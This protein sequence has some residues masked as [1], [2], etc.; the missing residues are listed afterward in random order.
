MQLQNFYAQDVNGNIVPGAICSL[1]LPGT[2]TLATGLV[3]VNGSTLANPFAAN[4]NGLVQFAA[5]NGAYDLKIEAGLIVSTLP[6]VFADTLQALIQL[7]GFLPPSATPPTTRVDGSTLQIGDRYMKTP[8]DIEYIYKT[9]GWEPNN[10]DGQLLAAANGASLVTFTPEGPGAFNRELQEKVRERACVRDFGGPNTGDGVTDDSAAALAMASSLG[11]IRFTRGNYVINTCEF[12]VPVSFD[13]KANVKVNSGNTLSI[14]NVIESPKQYIFKGDGDFALGHNHV[15]DTGENARQVHVSWFGAFP[16]PDYGPDQAPFFK[17]A[18]DSMG[19]GRESEI[20]LDIGNYNIA[21]TSLMVMTRACHLKG[22]GQRRTVLKLSTDIGPALTTGNTACRVTGIGFELHSTFVSTRVNPF[23]QLNHD[24]CD[25]RDV[26]FGNTS[27]GLIINALNCRV[28][29]V[30]AGYNANPPAGS[31]LI[32]AKYG[33]STI[34]NIHCM[35]SSGFGPEQVIRLGNSIANNE[36]AFLVENVQS[37]LPSK[38]VT[39]D[40]TIGSVTNSI[41]DNI[42]YTGFAGAAPE[43]V[44]H[45]RTGSDRDISGIT[46][47]NVVGTSYAA[48]FIKIEQAST[49]STKDVTISNSQCP[50]SATGYGVGFIQTAG[51]LSDITVSSTVNVKDRTT[52]FFYSGSTSRIK[53]APEAIKDALPAVCF[54]A[55]LADDSAVGISLNRSVFTGWVFVSASYQN[56]GQYIIRAASTPNLTAIQQTAN[57]ANTTGILT[58][59]T[60]TDGKLTFSVADKMLYVENRLGSTQRISVN[61]MTGVS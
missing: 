19:N 2:T 51:V 41:I 25:V 16:N 13:K 43:A 45:L 28:D 22:R 7:G 12:S 18:F 38:V 15:T 44:I 58:G 59:T 39:V 60:G 49:G 36:S 57:V 26:S 42:R 33:G 3:D 52:D 8:E 1:F 31:A 32:W 9:S 30:I 55:S 37:V 29:G 24:L 40:A 23:I 46:I 48:N 50:G 54:D 61:L 6:I 14:S 10:L 20:N 27:F 47:N 4:S 34:R 53:I 21:D 11:F 56:G 5:P 35:T 17:K